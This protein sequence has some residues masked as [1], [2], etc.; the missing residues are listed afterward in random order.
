MNQ[1]RN[2]GIYALSTDLLMC[3]HCSMFLARAISIS[4]TRRLH[5]HPRVIRI[6]R[7]QFDK[8][9]RRKQARAARFSSSAPALIGAY[10]SGVTVPRTSLE[11]N[12]GGF[13]LTSFS[14]SGCSPAI[15]P[16]SRRRNIDSSD[17][18]IEPP[19]FVGE[20]AAKRKTFE[21]APF[22]PM[23]MSPMGYTRG[24]DNNGSI[25]SNSE[26]SVFAKT[27]APNQTA[28]GG[29][30]TE[31]AVGKHPMWQSSSTPRNEI[32]RFTRNRQ[33]T[34]GRTG[35]A[36]LMTSV[37][38]GTD[39]RMFPS[40]SSTL[41]KTQDLTAAGGR[42]KTSVSTQKKG[43][44]TRKSN[45]PLEGGGRSKTGM[46]VLL[47]GE[48]ARDYSSLL[49]GTGELKAKDLEARA[50]TAEAEVCLSARC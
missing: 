28:A 50:A 2:I 11:E 37:R 38:T 15:L 49:K 34:N 17:H 27:R 39:N 42:S 21:T 31:Q 19:A 33:S 30:I 10:T 22:S 46:R 16:L 18:G 14:G 6:C 45:T 4:A 29:S 43:L 26:T 9:I 36:E 44:L 23:A 20:T 25:S 5:A 1:S 13:P 7:L 47:P 35:T 12:I 48:G 40:G 24:S 41:A 3:H 8:E 32:R